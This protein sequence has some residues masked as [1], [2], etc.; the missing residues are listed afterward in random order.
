MLWERHFD[1]RPPAD[2]WLERIAFLLAK[3]GMM[4]ESIN[5]VK[6]HQ[7]DASAWVFWEDSEEAKQKEEKSE[8]R[9]I[10]NAWG[11]AYEILVNENRGE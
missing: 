4:L 2:V 8:Q 10:E 7:V 9:E 5:T 3:T 1:R 6:E 11:A